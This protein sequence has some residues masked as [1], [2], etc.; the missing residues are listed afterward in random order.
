MFPVLPVLLG[1]TGMLAIAAVPE[2][3]HTVWAEALVL[4]VAVFCIGFGLREFF[5]ASAIAVL[6]LPIGAAID[7][8][9]LS[10]SVLLGV[11][12]AVAGYWSIRCEQRRVA[13]QRGE[14]A[15]KVKLFRQ[16]QRCATHL[17]ATASHD[18]RQPV[19]A[20]VAQVD[21]MKGKEGSGAYLSRRQLTEL[22]TSVHTLAEMLDDLFDV[23]RV[24]LGISEAR[25]QPVNV[26][27]LLQEV[28]HVFAVSANAKGLRLVTECP[29]DV[30]ITSDLKLL[31]RI[32]FNLTANAIRYTDAGGIRLSCLVAEG[33]AILQTE[34]TGRGMN[35][36]HLVAT[37]TQLEL[38][39]TPSYQGLGLGL[40]LGIAGMMAL[41]LGHKLRVSSELGEGT[42]IE[43]ELGECIAAASGTTRMGSPLPHSADIVVAIVEDDVAVLKALVNVLASWGCRTVSATDG[44]KLVKELR[45]CGAKPDFMIADLNLGAT[46]TGL[47]AIREVRSIYRD[48]ELPAIL[49]TGD[50]LLELE[51]DSAL[52][53]VQV[54]C[55]PVRPSALRQL[56]NERGLMK[57]LAT[58]PA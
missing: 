15:A 2:S 4:A 28:D 43:V 20:L 44:D 12:A 58:T 14:P 54:L 30:W 17:L 49:L 25:L 16:E 3:E 8:L 50:V 51:H 40:G 38:R 11:A 21:L 13:T 37:S 1:L 32:L 23:N 57:E 18:L 22:Q 24:N 7:C 19:Q 36:A 53:G 55:K 34:D 35:A 29:G 47:D 56:L 33:R 9:H 48:P 10:P 42:R 52:V 5:Y 26:R 46:Q 31:R 6:P 27:S 39:P 45:L 41:R